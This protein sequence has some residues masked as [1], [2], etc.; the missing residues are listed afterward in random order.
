MFLPKQ[1]LSLSLSTYLSNSLPLFFSLPLSL[2][3]YIYTHTH[4]HTHIYISMYVK[5]FFFVLVKRD[6]K[7]NRSIKRF[8]FFSEMPF[9][10]CM[11]S[12]CSFRQW[13]YVAQGHMNGAPNESRTHS[14]IFVSRM[15]FSWFVSVYI[16]VT[17][18]VS[19]NLIG[20]PIHMP[21]CH[22]YSVMKAISWKPSR[23]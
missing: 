18:W 2:Y 8:L 17:A 12:A 14:C 21:L 20:Y 15:F 4:T 13:S 3:I 5:M 1:T 19:S 10:T 16:E 11:F 9:P 7:M 6:F 22:I 23:M